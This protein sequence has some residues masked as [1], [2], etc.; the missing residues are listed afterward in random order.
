M[1]FKP[2]KQGKY[3]LLERL[4]SGGMAEVYRAKADGAGGFVKQLAVKRILPNY[5]QN[6]EF[7]KMFEYEARLSSQLTQANIVQIYDFIQS[8]DMYLLAMEFVDGKNLRQVINK[9]KKA[10]VN[11]PIP[12][13]VS[14]VNEASKGLDYAHKKKDDLTGQALNIIHRDMSPQNIMC[15]YEGAIKIVDFGI[16]KAKDKVDE[17]R[18][19]VI[20]GKFGYMSPEQANGAAVDARSDIFSTVIILWELVTGRR[21]FTAE[22][23]LATLK[24]IQE[25]QITPPSKLNPNVKPELERII[26]KGLTKDVSLRFTEASSLSRELQ[27]YLARFYPTFSQKDVSDVLTK[28]FK[29]EIE[30]EKKRWEEALKKSISFSQGGETQSNRLATE[31]VEGA[32]TQS[33][34]GSETGV[35]G[36]A[37]A[38]MSAER[39]GATVV[40]GG[41]SD[42]MAG[43]EHTLMDLDSASAMDPS[44]MALDDSPPPS[45]KNVTPPPS[46]SKKQAI[47]MPG[48]SAM[49]RDEDRTMVSEDELVTPSPFSG[50]VATQGSPKA[51][52]KKRA[53]TESKTVESANVPA[54]SDPEV[55]LPGQQSKGSGRHTN[56]S[57]EDLRV[58][59]PQHRG[60]G[61]GNKG[62]GQNAA[63]H[64][65]YSGARRRPDTKERS[66]ASP[67]RNVYLED[68]FEVRKKSKVPAYVAAAS[69]MI[70]LG[71]GALTYQQGGLPA[72]IK[73][74]SDRG[75]AEG[76]SGVPKVRSGGGGGSQ[77]A[78]TTTADEN[79]KNENQCIV[80]ITSDPPG[81]TVSIDR[82]LPDAVKSQTTPATFVLPCGVAKNFTIEHADYQSISENIVIKKRTEDKYWT[83]KKI[84]QGVVRLIISQN[85]NV[86][87]GGN[88]L[89]YLPAG[90]AFSVVLRAGIRHKFKFENEVLGINQ[91]KEIEVEDGVTQEVQ[92]KLEERVKRR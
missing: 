82:G 3:V 59:E 34:T 44:M 78:Q 17:T 84:P 67:N 27:G 69:V 7:Q 53:T 51:N 6:E 46:P 14:V 12:F 30:V 22:N 66:P 23:D 90:E 70:L 45:A 19:G 65:G 20:K 89:K 49:V 88:S 36:A 58:K 31:G 16:A 80:N 25:C 1:E 10:N 18:S 83:L 50:S 5:S 33:E 92:V 37:D 61:S 4:A 41:L 9:A 24:M 13:S 42:G 74:I 26:M 8:G 38:D 2:F 62:D 32:V 29:E 91:E 68:M 35:T 85:A 52:E 40:S 48:K 60:F 47:P 15:S 11:I 57:A 56:V 43:K 63:S 86:S 21:L 55:M 81:S 77:K 72:L 75:P 54:V 71:G 79:A 73:R 28:V 64:V 76:T 87:V 39:G